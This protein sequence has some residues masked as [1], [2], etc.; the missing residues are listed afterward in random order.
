MRPP[1]AFCNA[2]GV[3]GHRG[4]LHRA[5][6]LTADLA[7]ILHLAIA[8]AVARTRTL[9]HEAAELYAGGHLFGE[10]LDEPDTEVNEDREPQDEVENQWEA[11]P[12]GETQLDEPA[13]PLVSVVAAPG[14]P[15]QMCRVLAS[16]LVQCTASEKDL[17]S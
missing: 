1:R 2:L 6:T 4:N 3:L 5:L 10:L 14:V 16:R 9:V 11:L 13:A 15:S 17:T 12:D 8:E 7:G